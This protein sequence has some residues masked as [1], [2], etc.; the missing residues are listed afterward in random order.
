M[1]IK[2]LSSDNDG[3]FNNIFRSFVTRE[4]FFTDAARYLGY[5]VDS[6]QLDIDSENKVAS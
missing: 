1:S 6:G 4:E 3:I 2:W 5:V